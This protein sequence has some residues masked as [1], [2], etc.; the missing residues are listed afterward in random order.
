MVISKF[1][2]D[3]YNALFLVNVFPKYFEES[4]S[5]SQSDWF[6]MKG[7][8]LGRYLLVQSQQ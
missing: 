4:H 3:P 6:F 5:L 1:I 2:R 8:L 7:S